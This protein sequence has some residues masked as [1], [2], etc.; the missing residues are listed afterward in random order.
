MRRRLYSIWVSEC[1][2][3]SFLRNR[4]IGSGSQIQ[5]VSLSACARD[6]AKLANTPTI[7]DC[8]KNLDRV[9]S[10]KHTGAGSRKAAKTSGSRK[11][12]AELC[13][14]AALREPTIVCSSDVFRVSADRSASIRVLTLSLPIGVFGVARRPSCR[15]TDVDDYFQGIVTACCFERGKTVVET[16]PGGY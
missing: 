16:E 1:Q 8:V 15:S 13:D 10:L 14:F 7:R 3:L 5:E 2:Q 12:A 9:I 6:E 11:V 4:E